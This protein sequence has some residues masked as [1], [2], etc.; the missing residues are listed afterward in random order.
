VENEVRVPR[1]LGD[2]IAGEEVDVPATSTALLLLHPKEILDPGAI[3][4]FDACRRVQLSD[5]LLNIGR[6]LLRII[7]QRPAICTAEFLADHP[8]RHRVNVEADD[9]AAGA[10][11][12]EKR[13]APA[14]EWVG[15]GDSFE[16]LA[17]EIG[18]PQGWVSKLGQ[19]ETAEE[20]TGTTGEP[21][22][23][24]DHRPVVLLDLFFFGREAS[25]E[26]HVEGVLDH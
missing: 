17:I 12:F 2:E 1:V 13:R 24:A 7:S 19:E 20:C 22:V 10:V 3:L 14:H 15:D 8:E 5:G 11:R 9:I 26:A 23:D 16:M 6:Y 25:Y 21:F 4:A 18:S